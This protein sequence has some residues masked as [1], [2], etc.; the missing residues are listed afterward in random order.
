[1]APPGRRSIVAPAS[2]NHVPR[3]FA[4]VSAVQTRSIEAAMRIS[5]SI[6]SGIIAL[7]ATG[8]S[9]TR[10]Y[11]VTRQDGIAQPRSYTS[12]GSNSTRATRSTF[13][14]RLLQSIVQKDVILKT[15]LLHA[16]TGDESWRRLK[17][18]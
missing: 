11:I 9:A 2:P 10:N 17:D 14:Y 3:C 4:S 1:M 6:R 13:R 16:Q 18:L 8:E 5:R 7:L 12:G 15:P